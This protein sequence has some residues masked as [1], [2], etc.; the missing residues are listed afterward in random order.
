MKNILILYN[1]VGLGH[2]SIAENMAGHLRQAGFEVRLGDVL[3]EQ[4]G[5]LSRL[6]TKIYYVIS[7]TFPFIWSFLYIND[8]LAK[9]LMPF[10]VMVAAKNSGNV[11]FLIGDFKP[12]LII[13]TH[14]NA[15]AIVAHLKQAGFYKGLFGIAFSDFHLHRF[16]LYF[17]A[18]FYLA[19]IKEQKEEMTEMGV[20][21]EKIF[22]CGFTLSPQKPINI[23]AARSRFGIPDGN[24]VAL[25]A[26]GSAGAGLNEGLLREL[27]NQKHLSVIVVC[28]SNKKTERD[29]AVK[30][31]GTN[32]I[33]LGYYSPMEELY[34]LANIFVTKAG[35]LSVSEA[36]RRRLP[37]LISYVLPGQEELNYDYLIEKGLVMPEPINLAEEIVEE[38][39]TGSFANN[40]K[41][42]L[43]VNEIIGD[44]EVL[45][46]IIKDFLIK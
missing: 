24:R 6:G 44:P 11:K 20:A 32:I 35:G 8:W 28:G 5:A 27:N 10:R 2:K 26:G 3:K 23:K 34:A 18:D 38:L 14:T 1:S 17:Q 19:N 30:F 40:L 31:A 16:W 7:Q 4:E 45:T 37:I 25:V 12:D 39:E 46:E 22:I 42:N 41:N 13:S 9:I 15:S 21:A 43:T 36:L 29:L 33:V